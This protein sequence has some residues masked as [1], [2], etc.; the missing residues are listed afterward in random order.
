[1]KKKRE[2]KNFLYKRSTLSHQNHLV[3]EPD[4]IYNREGE[5]NLIFVPGLN[6]FG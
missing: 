2:I 5:L 4:I 3:C 1:M 6:G